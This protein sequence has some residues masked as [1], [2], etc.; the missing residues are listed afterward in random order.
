MTEQFA[1]F[2]QSTLSANC[3][4]TD[5]VI[6]VANA[7]SF[8]ATGNFRIVVQT[9]DAS[10]LTPIGSPEL[11]LVTSV[12]GNN[13]FTVTRG[14]EGTT[15]APFKSG[16]KVNHILTAAVMTALSA[17]GS[18]VSSINSQTGAITL[19]SSGATISISTPSSGV[20]NLE[21]LGGGS[22]ILWNEVT[23]TT[24]A[25]AVSNGYIMNNASTVVGTL[26]ATAAQGSQIN[27]AGKGAGG[28]KVAQNSGQTIHFDGNNTTTGVTGYLASQ[29]TFDCLTL[30]CI[31][32]NTDW[33]VTSS[34]GNITGN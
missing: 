19:Q 24:V 20:I 23:T 15:Q 16:A 8:P 30:L 5:T 29:T 3:G 32:A 18:G 12:L 26:P 34:I 9:Y 27:I 10:G 17:G 7:S 21:S 14:I 25:L 33:L 4:S 6:H 13:S 2:A 1:N 31:T 28:W 22:G 11:M